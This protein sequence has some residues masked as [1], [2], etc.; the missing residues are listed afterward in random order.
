[1]NAERKPWRH[2]RTGETIYDPAHGSFIVDGIE[3]SPL[4]GMRVRLVNAFNHDQA[5]QSKVD[6]NYVVTVVA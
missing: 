2:V 4:F 1:M 5:F 6:R 3:D